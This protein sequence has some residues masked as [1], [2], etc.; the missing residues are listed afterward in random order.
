MITAQNI[1][2][3]YCKANHVDAPWEMLPAFVRVE[4]D[5]MAIELNKL[6]DDVVTITAVRCPSCHEML[7]V[8][9]CELHPCFLAEVQR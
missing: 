7:D 9:H 6:N 2:Q 8:E 5:A 1:H 4:Y 3:A